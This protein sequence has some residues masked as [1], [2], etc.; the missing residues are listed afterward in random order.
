VSADGDSVP[1]RLV[2]AAADEPVLALFVLLL[3]V[4]AVGFLLA[5]LVVV[6]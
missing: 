2:G 6:L 1:R 4:L 3:L 5:L